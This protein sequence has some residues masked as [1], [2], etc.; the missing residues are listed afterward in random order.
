M[1]SYDDT[2]PFHGWLFAYN[3]VDLHAAAAVL[4][5]TRNGSNGG[6]GESGGA[7]SSDASGN[8]F[9]V[10][11]DGTF[12]ANTGGSDYAETLLKLQMSSAQP[13]A[14]YFTPSNEFTLNLPQ[15]HFGS[16]GVLLLPDSAG[17]GVPLA[18]TGSEAGTL[19]LVDRNNLGAFNGPNGPDKVIQTLALSG[20]LFGTPAYWS[21]NNSVYVAAAGDNVRVLPLTTGTLASPSCSTSPSSCSADILSLLGASPVISWDGSNS[22][23]GILWALDTSGSATS[24]PAILHAY[25]ATNLSTLYSSASVV[26]DATG[27]AVKFAVPT[28]ANGKVYIGTQDELSVYGPK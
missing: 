3:A 1:I 20:S 5:T 14:D 28:V 8:V 4:N 23:S 9:V 25:D 17:G 22:A 12:D 16:T 10:T 21:A 27:L 7:P 24:S 15:K 11:S 19:Y 13:L 2:E 18:L 6:I 26:S